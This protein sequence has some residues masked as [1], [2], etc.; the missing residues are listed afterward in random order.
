MQSEKG[1]VGNVKKK[2]QCI[3]TQNVAMV[4]VSIDH[5]W[6]FLNF[7]WSAPYIFIKLLGNAHASLQKVFRP[8]NFFYILLRYS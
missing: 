4:N 6:K 3:D 8:L 7:Y 1:F 5:P 2:V